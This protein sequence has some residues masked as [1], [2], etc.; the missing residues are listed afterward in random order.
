MMS[1]RA[2]QDLIQHHHSFSAYHP[3]ILQQHFS[4]IDRS[5]IDESADMPTVS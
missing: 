2:I 1:L 5:F 3:T 4:G